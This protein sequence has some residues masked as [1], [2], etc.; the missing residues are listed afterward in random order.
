MLNVRFGS[1]ADIAMGLRDV[2]FTPKSGHLW[3]RLACLLC[4]KSGHRLPL[5]NP[6]C[7]PARCLALRPRDPQNKRLEPGK[8]ESLA[9]QM[10]GTA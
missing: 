7:G 2:R 3:L 4:A 5:P 8:G 1:L 9:R 6:Q 10:C